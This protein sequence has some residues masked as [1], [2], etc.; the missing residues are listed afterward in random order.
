MWH[1]IRENDSG[2]KI[3]KKQIIS[4]DLSPLHWMKKSCRKLFLLP[5]MF[6]PCRRQFLRLDL[7]PAF[8]FI[9][10]MTFFIDWFFTVWIIATLS[11]SNPKEK[12]E[13]LSQLAC[14]EH[15]LPFERVHLFVFSFAIAKNQHKWKKNEK[16]NAHLDE[17]VI[18]KRR[19]TDKTKTKQWKETNFCLRGNKKSSSSFY[20]FVFSIFFVASFDAV[21]VHKNNNGK[22]QKK[23]TLKEDE[24]FIEKN[25]RKRENANID[26]VQKRISIKLSE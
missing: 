21:S 18:A 1:R 19:P 17:N 7:R 8:F 12:I 24:N 5:K 6:F 25:R 9:S 26:D 11:S 14:V 23:K 10:M 13:F 22:K 15:S 2:K 20:Y 16:A 3:W 4:I